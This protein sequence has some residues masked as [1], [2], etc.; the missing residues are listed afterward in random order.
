MKNNIIAA[1]AIVAVGF[2]A[3]WFDT[4]QP[5]IR[6]LEN[7]GRVVDLFH[8]QHFDDLVQDTP[9][10]ARPGA[11]VLFFDSSITSHDEYMKEWVAVIETKFPSRVDLLACK[12]DTLSVPLRMWYDF[13]PELDLVRR[14]NIDTSQPTLVWIPPECSG[15]VDWCQRDQRLDGT[16]VMGCGNFTD[17]CANLISKHS[18][19][20]VHDGGWL[21]KRIKDTPRPAIMRAYGDTYASQEKLLKQRDL[22][23][24]DN[25]LRNNY[26]TK[27][28]PG[29][30]RDGYKLVAIP[31]EIQ[32]WLEEF[33]ES[34][35]GKKKFERW[36]ADSTQLNVHESP[37][38]FTDLDM[39]AV[40]RSNM[41]TKYLEPIVSEWAGTSNIELTSFYGVREYND[42]AILKNHIDRISTHV[43]SITL[44]I[45]KPDYDKSRENP[46]PLEVI[47]FHGNHIRAE[48]TNGTM[49]LYESSKLPHGRPY[50][51][52]G[53]RHVACFVHYKPTGREWEDES[54]KALA[55]KENHTT[56]VQYRTTKVRESSDPIYIDSDV[57]GGK[58]QWH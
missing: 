58:T 17:H 43:L 25:H 32:V 22:T 39:I 55:Y 41:A 33:L 42:G 20:N 1:V 30:T 57:I 9:R 4:T 51:N 37:T 35:V 5:T 54:K 19:G 12:Y 28:L 3:S 18:G 36:N 16:T 10:E 13:V 2:L 40:E 38:M 23:T 7:G 46:W 49:I 27:S 8:G 21:W 34:N 45:D 15:V 26:M 50:Y 31:Q 47:D 29:F 53:G 52:R 48:H 6:L 14:W 56:W 24:T 44:S 11:V